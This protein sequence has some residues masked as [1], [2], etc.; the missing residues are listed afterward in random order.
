MVRASKVFFYSSSVAVESEGCTFLMKLGKE[1]AVMP[2]FDTCELTISVGD[3]NKVVELF[4]LPIVITVI[5]N[6]FL[7]L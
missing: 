5:R 4:S 7:N 3:S 1:P 6:E 2:L